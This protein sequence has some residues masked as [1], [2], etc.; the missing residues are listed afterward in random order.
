MLELDPNAENGE[1]RLVS[2]GISLENTTHCG[3][4]CIMCPRDEFSAKWS[5]MDDGLFRDAID[6][7]APLGLKYVGLSGFGDSFMDPNYENKLRYVRENYPYVRLITG[8]T[9]HLLNEKNIEKIVEL[10]DTIKISLYGHSKQTY[11]A[12]HKG[13]LKFEKISENIHRLCAIPREERPY[14][15]LSFLMLP[16]NQHET[17]AWIEHWEPLADEVLVWRPHNFG[18]AETIEDIAFQ[19]DA[20]QQPEQQMSCGRP[21][22]GD[23]SIRANGDVTVCCFDFNHKM[24]IGNLKNSSLLDILNGPMMTRIKEVHEAKAF[25]GCGLLCDGCDQLY[26][27]E[28]ASVYVSNK[29]RGIGQQTTHPD[30]DAQYIA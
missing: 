18:G 3:A 28:D 7:A 21:F 22:K 25:D 1:Q 23:P 5:H 6:Q 14:V 20:N 8:T 19:T 15:I 11:E 24:V 16:E 2:G 12:V 27:R 26:D 29:K 9:G 10:Y 13:V 30:R 4:K 17:D